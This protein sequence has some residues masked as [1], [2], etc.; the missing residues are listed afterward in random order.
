MEQFDAYLDIVPEASWPGRLMIGSD[1]PVCTLASSFG[2]V[3][4]LA[5]RYIARL[6]RNKQLLSRISIRTGAFHP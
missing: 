5:A 4:S 6:S 2:Q 1:C 3:I